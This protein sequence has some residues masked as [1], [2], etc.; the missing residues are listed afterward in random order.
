VWGALAARVFP[1]SRRR[2][3]ALRHH[4]RVC[5]V[6]VGVNFLLYAGLPSYTSFIGEIHVR[7]AVLATA[8]LPL[9]AAPPRRRERL[10]KGAL[11]LLALA[12]A[13]NAWL[14]LERFDREARGFDAVV[15]RIPYGARILAL[16]W[17]AN[18]E[19]MRT[20]P[21]WHFAA[22]AQARRGGLVA[23]TF[24]A[25]FWNLPVRL[26]EDAG[27]PATPAVL[28]AKPY[29]FDYE[30]FG[31]AYD[32]VLVRQGETEGRDRFARFPYRLV[33]EAPPW[34]LWRRPGP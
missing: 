13:A 28:F 26:R 10:A 1:V 31:Y 34:Q 29:L 18:G 32:H 27:L 22:Y 2:W 3:D 23:Q 21:Y 8:L 4:E 16:T 19:V 25:M 20:K 30:R 11:V 12:A 5:W 24:P 6:F 7:H 33:F 9:L 15:E 17:D 14:H